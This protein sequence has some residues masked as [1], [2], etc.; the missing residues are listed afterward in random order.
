MLTHHDELFACS[1]SKDT[2]PTEKPL[3]SLT[4][5]KLSLIYYYVVYFNFMQNTPTKKQMQKGGETHGKEKAFD[6]EYQLSSL[7]DEHQ[8]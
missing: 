2:V 1:P 4:L 8:E 7:C 6:P 3:D 5:T